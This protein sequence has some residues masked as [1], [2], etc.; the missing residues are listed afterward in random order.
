MR[1]PDQGAQPSGGGGACVQNAHA[2][3]VQAERKY[4]ARRAIVGASLPA[5][6]LPGP[7]GRAPNQ[8]TNGG[9]R[10]GQISASIS[11]ES[12]PDLFLLRAR[13]AQFGFGLSGLAFDLPSLP[14]LSLELLLLLRSDGR[15]DCG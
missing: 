11:P 9:R 14:W 4:Y 7:G 8:T 10:A 6:A 12:V 15:T 3:A 1:W 5:G 13:K 2:V